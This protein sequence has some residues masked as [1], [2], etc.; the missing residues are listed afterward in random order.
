MGSAIRL[1][2]TRA[3]TT[4]NNSTDLSGEFVQPFDHNVALDVYSTFLNYTVYSADGNRVER[5]IA[6]L[7][8]RDVWSATAVTRLT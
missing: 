6:Q 2:E 7:A 1:S 5:I 4:E 3:G 8:R